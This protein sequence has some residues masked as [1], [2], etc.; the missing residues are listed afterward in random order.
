MKKIFIDC[1]G[2]VGESIKLFKKSKEYTKDFIIYSFEP[3]SYLSKKYRGDE[4]IIFLDRALW[5]YDG[6]IDFYLA[7][8]SDGNSLFKSKE[9]GNLDKDHPI[10][11]KCID[12]SKWIQNVFDKSD[13]IILK[14]DIEGAEFKVLN[15]M[16]EDRSIEYINKIY[17]EWHFSIDFQDKNMHREIIDKLKF[18]NI[19]LYPE[20]KKCLKKN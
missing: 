17:I 3:V 2:H 5:I 16:I 6:E 14:M 20:M 1:G 13:Y 12:F 18:N 19:E 7:E 9:T 11:V 8:Q 15:K 10:K 4:N